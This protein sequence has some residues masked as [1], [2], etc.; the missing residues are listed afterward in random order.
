MA[1]RFGR[2]QR[3]ALLTEVTKLNDRISDLRFG[4]YR[5]ATGRYPALNELGHIIEQDITDSI[6]RDRVSR[7]ATVVLWVG[8]TDLNKWQ[9]AS[10]GSYVEWGGIVWKLDAIDYDAHRGFR[11]AGQVEVDLIAMGGRS[12]KTLDINTFQSRHQTIS[13]FGSRI[14]R[15]FDRSL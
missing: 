15:P 8:D 4:Y 14:T 6:S 9:N 1:K 7:K 11:P 3:R 10:H 5:E 2:N 12:P 13:D